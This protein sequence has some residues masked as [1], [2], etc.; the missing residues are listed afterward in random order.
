LFFFAEK[1]FFSALSSD[2][3][4]ALLRLV[5]P[6]NNLEKVPL[7]NLE[8]YRHHRV[9][10]GALERLERQAGKR[11]RAVLRGR[12]GSNPA[13]LPGAQTKLTKLSIPVIFNHMVE[14][15][16][17]ALDRTFHALAN[18]TRRAILAQLAQKRATVLEIAAQ[19]DMSLNGVS[20]H[21]KVLEEAGLIR[22]EI[23]GRT[24]YCSLEAEPLR[25]AGEWISYYRQY[26]ENRL[27]R[28]ERFLARK[29]AS[30]ES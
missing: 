17:P 26:W 8:G 25:Q 27:D 23:N 28:L 30:E 20:K 29:H 9:P 24:H 22:R 21:L 6:P 3:Q 1:S 18:P 16:M 19:F 2:A 14:Y 11:A 12:D 15:S 4:S 10:H 5:T 13:R 7:L